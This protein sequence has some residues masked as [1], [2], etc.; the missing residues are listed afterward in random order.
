[1]SHKKI[2]ILQETNN[3]LTF[4]LKMQNNNNNN[5]PNN[6][7]QSND[8]LVYTKQITNSNHVCFIYVVR[9]IKL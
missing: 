9:C 2:I 4:G 3:F 8:V 6:S 7:K 5:N 1:M